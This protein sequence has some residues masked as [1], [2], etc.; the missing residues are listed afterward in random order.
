[1]KRVAQEDTD[2]RNLGRIILD[3]LGTGSVLS[4][5]AYNPLVYY[6]HLLALFSTNHM[7]KMIVFPI[8]LRCFSPQWDM[9]P[10]WQFDDEIQHIRRSI[11]RRFYWCLSAKK[12]YATKKDMIEFRNNAIDYP[13]S[14]LKTVGEFLDIV[15][16]KP[17]DIEQKFLRKKEIFVFHYMHP[18]VKEHRK[19]QAIGRSLRLLQKTNT[20]VLFY[21]TPINVHGGERFVGSAFRSQVDANI[22]VLNSIFEPYLNDESVQYFDWSKLFDSDL[23]FNEDLATEHLNQYGRKKLAR[24]IVKEIERMKTKSSS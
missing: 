7:P 14:C 3:K 4:N 10:K 20:K 13:S 11:G 1:M 17:C 23:F 15:N 6:N 22:A 5:S 18:L 12:K 9:N 16:S 2:K 19:M 8:N 24:R 21:I